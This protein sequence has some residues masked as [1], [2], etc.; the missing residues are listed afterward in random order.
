MGRMRRRSAQGPDEGGATSVLSRWL[1]H[2]GALSPYGMAQFARPV[3]A[4]QRVTTWRD[5]QAFAAVVAPLTH[6]LGWR[7]RVR[8][9]AIGAATRPVARA[10]AALTVLGLVAV[11]S[12]SLLVVTIADAWATPL[13]LALAAG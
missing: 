10:L 4:Q 6:D 11:A 8:R 7:L 12:L 9:L 1:L 3:P 13:R 2:L 5:D